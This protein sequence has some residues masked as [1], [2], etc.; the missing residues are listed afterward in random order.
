M[1]VHLTVVVAVEII[2]RMVAQRV[3]QDATPNVMRD[4]LMHATAVKVRVLPSA[5]LDVVPTVIP[6]AVKIADP[7]AKQC[8][9]DAPMS[10]L[11]IVEVVLKHVLMTALTDVFHRALNNVRKHVWDRVQ[12]N[13]TDHVLAC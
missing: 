5:Q 3:A 11:R 4:A 6:F 13:V 9:E 1:D 8:V 7:R 10:V 12:I 2:V